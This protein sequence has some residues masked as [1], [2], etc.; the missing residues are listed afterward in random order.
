MKNKDHDRIID[1]AIKILKNEYNSFSK[2]N[3]EAL[4]KNL[5]ISK[6][7]L[8]Q[9]YLAIERLNPFPASHFTNSATGAYISP[10][11][12]VTIKDEKNEVSLTKRSGKDI[13]V[14]SQYQKMMSQTI[15]K[16]AKE[17]LKQKIESANWFK[18][19]ILQREETLLKVMSSIVLI[20]D[21]YFKSG[22]EGK[23]KAMK[24]ADIAEK[25][26]MDI[27]T[28]SRVTNSKYVQTF[29]GIFLLKDLF[30]EA[31]SK[32]NGEVISTKSIKQRLKEIIEQEDKTRPFTDESLCEILG[33]D[34]YHI[35]RRTVAKYR[36]SLGIETSRYRR[37][38]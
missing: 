8:K 21:E 7:D 29:F 37:E 25:V 19:A 30:S 22:D 1:L 33:R 34:E 38:L 13:Q 10:D 18:K 35:A 23:I 20:Q 31:Y 28:I 9:V 3:Y 24:L 14:S 12:I 17:F 15:D 6:S 5:N 36:E 26:G 16:E 4:I 2:K 11:F 32:E 27:S